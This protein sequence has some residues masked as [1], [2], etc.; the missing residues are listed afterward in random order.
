MSAQYLRFCSLVVGDPSG[1]GIELS[2]LRVKF[3]IDKSDTQSPASATIRVYNLSDNT[4]KQIQNEF[5]HVF[6]QAGYDGN[7]ALIFNGTMRQKREGRENQTDT[8]LEIIAQDGDAGYNFSVVNTTLAA[9]WNQAS[10]HG[11]LM[12]AFSPFGITQG[13]TPEFGGPSMPRAKVC[14]GMTRD[15]MRTLADSA[16]TSWSIAD[17]ALHMIP[18][19]STLPGA[20]IVLTSD[21]GL[22]G[23][24]VQTISGI[25]VKSLLNPLI[26]YG[27][28]I[29][30]DNASIQTASFSVAYGA[31][32]QFP[33][34]DT[35]GFYKVYAVKM[36]GDTRGQEWYSDIICA[37]VNGTAPL[38]G[39]YVNATA[40]STGY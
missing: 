37:A 11:Q 14:Y 19:A 30:L 38:A 18:I 36:T 20:A 40:S 21:S 15:Y 26:K 32:N 27:G 34:L 28:Q 17:G 9:G 31:I 23:M 4:A 24:P 10:L 5:T 8:F 2:A 6:L 39:P 1:N 3:V 16:G 12:Q 7:H 13:Y 35:D 33:S 22:I 29:Q 25:V